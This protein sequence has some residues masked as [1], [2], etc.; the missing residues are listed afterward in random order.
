M[1]GLYR[2]WEGLGGIGKFSRFGGV[3]RR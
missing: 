3:R 1:D 2:T